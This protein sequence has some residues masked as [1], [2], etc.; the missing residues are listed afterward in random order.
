MN[1]CTVLRQQYSTSIT[2]PIWIKFI[3][4]HL[5]PPRQKIWRHGHTVFTTHI[6]VPLN[7]PFISLQTLKPHWFEPSNVCSSLSHSS[8]W[9]ISLKLSYVINT[10]SLIQSLKHPCEPI[11]KM[12]L[13]FFHCLDIFTSHTYNVSMFLQVHYTTN[14]GTHIYQ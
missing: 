6:I 3:T 5:P 7:W 12:H 11:T 1:T 10:V 9:L 13:N 2:M 8:D 4:C 14:T